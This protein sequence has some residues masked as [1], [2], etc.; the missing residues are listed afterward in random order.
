MSA[1]AKAVKDFGKEPNR[2]VNPDEV[3]A[4]GA[5]CRRSFSW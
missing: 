1:I 4:V 5:V 2:T 3:V